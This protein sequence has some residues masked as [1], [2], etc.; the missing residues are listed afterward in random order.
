[1][2]DGTADICGGPG[3]K[4]EARMARPRASDY[5][6]K[7]TAIFQTSARLFAEQGYDG[8]SMS[9][10]AV[11]CGVSKALLYHYHASK[12]D[13]LFHIIEDHLRQLVEAVETANGGA[14]S[15]RERLDHLAIALLE[16]YRDADAE[17][18]VQIN[19]LKRLPEERQAELRGLERK[20]VDIFA[21][22]IAAASPAL[23]DGSP[24]LKPVTMSLFG[25]LNWQFMWFRPKGP[26]S[27]ENYARLATRLIVEGGR[28]IDLADL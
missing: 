19:D 22:A 5:S 23:Q 15:P 20:L 9:Q 13:L 7:R 1:M 25:M 6:E 27:R 3:T 26:V 17:H 24:L 8:T 21:S 14:A 18:K 11:A 16:A 10:I 2:P 12:E 4:S 28:D